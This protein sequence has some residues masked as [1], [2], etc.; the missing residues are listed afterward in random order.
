MTQA[1][2]RDELFRIAEQNGGYALF[3][4]D[5]QQMTTLAARLPELIRSP[6]LLYFEEPASAPPGEVRIR[7]R[8]AHPRPELL[9]GGR[10][11]YPL[12]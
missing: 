7:L 3:V 4:P 1:L 5:R 6:Y 11:R 12:D 10:M 9:Y 8:G 2:G